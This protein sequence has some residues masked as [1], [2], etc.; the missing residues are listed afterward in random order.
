[1]GLADVMIGTPFADDVF[2]DAMQSQ[3]RMDPPDRWTT[4]KVRLGFV[5]SWPSVPV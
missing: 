4:T 1:M 2:R 5:L 3:S